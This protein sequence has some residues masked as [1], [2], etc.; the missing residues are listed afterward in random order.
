MVPPRIRI[1]EG[2][3]HL[4]P[5]EDV[6]TA[7][8]N[9]CPN[10]GADLPADSP[11]GLCPRCMMRGAL[12]EETAGTEGPTERAS[13]ETGAQAPPGAT[14]L[15]ATAAEAPT[16]GQGEGLPSRVAASIETGEPN[17]A[18]LTS[19]GNDEASG[20][21]RGAR[22]RY[23][24]DYE[25]LKELGRGGMGIVYQAR[26][27]S[28]NRPVALKML[29]SDVLASEDELRRFQNEADAVAI[30]DHPHIV[31]IFE[32]GAHEDRPYF[33][34][35][36]IAGPSLDRKRDEYTSDPRAAARLL[37]T[38]AEAVHHAHQRGILHRDLKPANILVDDRGEPHVTDF[39]L[40]KRVEGD[41]ELTQSGAILG[42]PAYMSPEQ[43]SGHRAAVTTASDVYGLGAVL[44]VLLA[45][46]APFVGDTVIDTIRQVRERAPEAPS[47]LNPRTPS[48]VE[49]ICLKC[50]EKA[51][52]RR[53]DSAQALAD[54][55]RRY[56]AG[57]PITARRTSSLKRAWLWCRRNPWLAGA[58][59]ATAAAVVA[60]A[61]ISTVFAI[62]QNRAKNR[63]KGLADNL[64]SSLEK[65]EGLASELKTSLRESYRRLARLDFE[66]AQNAFEKEQI[67]PGLLRLVQSWR[68]AI[69]ADDAGWRH[70]ARAG[71]SAWRQNLVEP[72]LVLSHEQQVRVIAFSPDG[73]AVITGSS[74]NT[75][76]LWNT[77]TGQPIAPPLRH[78]GGVQS[79]A[80]RPDGKAVLTG[81]LDNTAR[82]WDAA[83]GQPLAPP[84]R[85]QGWVMAVSFSPDGKTALTGSLDKTAQLWE[86]AT[87]RPVGSPMIHQA[88]VDAVRFS[89]DGKAVLTGSQD[90]TARVWDAASGQPVS[91]PLRHQGFVEGLAFR[92]DGRAVLTGSHDHT[93]RLWGPTNGQPIGVAM[94][95]Q[96]KITTV[97]FSPDGRA[98]LTGSYDHTAR[99]W[100]AATGQPIF[101]PLLHPDAVVAVAFRPD[102]KAI[103]TGCIDGVARLWDATTGLPLGLPMSH[104]GEVRA[105]AFSPD[106]RAA[107]TGSLDNTARVWEVSIG[108]RIGLPLQHHGEV[109]TV[110]FSPDGRTVLTGSYD[111]TARLWDAATGRP[112]GSPMRH[113]DSV[114]SVAFSPDGKAVLTGSGD[115]TARLWDVATGQP[116]GPP[117]QHRG[118]V[119]AVAFRPDGKAVL[120]GS[121]D[122]TARLWDAF[123]GRPLSPPLR[124]Q[125]WVNEVVFSPDGRS[126]LTASFD[127]ARLWDAASGQPIT[128][129]MQHQDSINAVAFSPDG[130]SVL[131]GSF[132]N[133]A[134]LW[135]AT[136]GRSITPPLRHQ[137]PVKCVT[138][139][140]D[141][142]SVLTGSH[143]HTAR[144]WD[145]A[146]GH[147]LGPA[148]RHQDGIWSAAFGP[149]GKMV[150]T[151]SYDNTV[152]RWDAATGRPI[153]PPLRHDGW[154]YSVAFSPDGRTL[155]TGCGDKTARLWDLP[156][157]PDEPER[158]SAWVSKATPLGLDDSDEVKVLGGAALDECRERLESLGG[159]PSRGQR[160]SLDP[161]LAGS[162]PAARA[163]ALIQ[164]G[165]ENE[166]MLAFDEAL[167]ARPLYAPLWAQRARFYASHGRLEQAI[168]DAA[169]AALVCWNDV[170]LASLTRRDAA[171]R[172]EVL[173]E[174]LQMQSVGCRRGPEVWRGRG[175]RRAAQRDW[176]GAVREF[177]APATPVPS[178][179]A[180]D[181]LAQA[182]LLRLAGESVGANRF[183]LE[184]RN[185]PERAPSTQADGTPYSHPDIQ[186]PLWVRLL[187]DLPLDPTDLVQRAESYITS[188]AGAGKYVLGTA[189]LRTGRLDEAVQQFE[190]SLAIEPEWSN[191]GMNFYGLAL[192]HHR[193]G[194]SN[195]ARRWLDRAEF[196]LNR[197]DRAY[198]A[199]APGILTGQ[200]QVAVTFEFWVYAQVVRR[201]AAG[202][203]LDAIF[204]ADPF[205]R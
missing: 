78:Q 31:P 38:V 89:P 61:V 5:R 66:R 185:L 153:G 55:L 27:I 12:G 11:E 43:A 88:M 187:D 1:K 160:P 113:Q 98:A 170:E 176:S 9:R 69:A 107:F 76:R 115:N 79:V 190:A 24:G 85:H 196:W 139:S 129:P 40:A 63:I 84:L 2:Q 92:P 42:T 195:E 166:A 22:V 191:S 94:R 148:L 193:L 36:L 37:A 123:S 192:G 20:F 23:F 112:V 72:R 93:A 74:D 96:A 3:T 6:M 159:A 174:I 150:A 135:D 141:G 44:Y 200:P 155:L 128:P 165:R 25:L 54:D 105:V 119:L 202:L 86:V 71:L 198:A 186:M 120:T 30:L 204:P 4:S 87:G 138:F 103:L 122:N 127:T 149:D 163:R 133:T 47:K 147:P 201:E 167:R 56:L 99:L 172:D 151:G 154:V 65:S 178:L 134:R 146:T 118:G 110:A 188:H 18:A 53:Y 52:A 125:D 39:G 121:Q 182:C 169:Q 106:G 126:I 45:G 101:P 143:D 161:I 132:D 137:G 26:Q 21:A 10:C 29:K 64:R 183:A 203:I 8:A 181:L 140:P 180:P 33:S 28:L 131:T 35:K 16:L 124:H 156:G 197:L 81:S 46:R 152:R 97:E 67:G 173:D 142:R 136:S 15:G 90:D 34:M 48:D 51:P 73:N 82:L 80:F 189:L 168:A 102:G 117:L 83:S 104:Q 13:D 50:L 184:V 77:A 68:S 100:D 75:A 157:L 109:Y 145:A 49:V 179:P 175:R 7:D 114:G 32:V 62:E 58:T 108:Q 19:D 59:G 111:D 70:A 177:A 95:H 91:P 158:V 194:H 116:I 57:E 60:V 14:Q 171:F 17:G 199:E 164:Q 130:K 41:S 144:L 205:A 162:D